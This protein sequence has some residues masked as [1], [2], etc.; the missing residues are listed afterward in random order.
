MLRAWLGAFKGLAHQS[1]AI[2]VLPL[3]ELSGRSGASP[4]QI[5]PLLSSGARV[6][7]CFAKQAV[8]IQAIKRLS[9]KGMI[10]VRAKQD[11]NGI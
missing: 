2:C 5:W 9:A 6:P 11:V 10:D 7:N 1:L 3:V 4:Y 8:R